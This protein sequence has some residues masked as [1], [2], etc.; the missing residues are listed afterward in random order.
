VAKSRRLRIQSVNRV[1]ALT[2]TKKSSKAIGLDKLAP[3]D[4]RTCARL[5]HASGGELEQIQLLLATCQCKARN[6]ILAASSEFNPRSM[7]GLASSP[8]F[9]LELR[10]ME[11][12]PTTRQDIWNLFRFR[13]W[14]ESEISRSYFFVRAGLRAGEDP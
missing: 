5:C 13:R 6:A 8:S 9:E 3:H 1:F 10:M 12:L 14:A 7:T 2:L 11:G 4:L